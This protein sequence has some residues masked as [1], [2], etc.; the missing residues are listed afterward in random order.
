MSTQVG[1]TTK[2]FG[3]N[4]NISVS[5]VGGDE[6]LSSSVLR[7]NTIIIDSRIDRNFEDIGTYAMFITDS[8]GKAVRLTYTIQPGNGLYVDEAD[9]DK[10]KM[11]IDGISIMAN[12]GDELYVNRNN[13]IDNNTLLSTGGKIRV[14]TTSLLR[15]T[16]SSVGVVKGDEHTITVSGGSMSVITY[17]LDTVDDESNRD[18]IMCHSSEMNRT[19]EAIDGKLNVLTQNLDKADDDTFGVI[20]TDGITT[21]ADDNGKLSVITSGLEDAHYAQKGIVCGDGL[22][23]VAVDGVLSV[24]T[25]NL[26]PADSDNYGVVMIDGY[27]LVTSKNN[28][29]LEVYR[30]PEIEALLETNNPEHEIFRRDIEDLKN[31][32]SKLETTHQQEI[33]DFFIPVGEQTT[34]LPEPVFDKKTWQIAERYTDRKTISFQIKSNCKF[35]I[36]VEYKE[37]TNDYG[38]VTLLNVQE[39]S[40]VT[41][42]ANDLAN[43]IFEATGNTVQTINFTFEV[44]NYDKDNNQSCENTQVI[45]TATSINDAAIKQTSFHIFKCWNNLAYGEDKP[46]YDDPEVFIE[47]ESY[48]VVYPKTA[49]L[50]LYDSATESQTA[51]LQYN[52]TSS[53]NYYFNTYVYAAYT[54]YNP[55]EMKYNEPKHYWLNQSSTSE[56]GDY[57]VTVTT[58]SAD[59]SWVSAT[60]TTSYSTTRKFNVLQVKSTKPITTTSRTANITVALSPSTESQATIP[61]LPELTDTISTES[62]ESLINS[63]ENVMKT[64]GN[65]IRN[66]NVGEKIV[67]N[68]SLSTSLNTNPESITFTYYKIKN[69]IEELSKPGGLLSELNKK[70]NEVSNDESLLTDITE[71][72]KYSTLKQQ[73]TQTANKII[74]EYGVARQITNKISD[75][76]SDTLPKQLEFKYTELLNA[77]N[78]EIFVKATI[79]PEKSGITFTMTRNASSYVVNDKWSFTPKYIFINKNG[80]VVD[81]SGNNT[82][83]EYSADAMY[84]GTAITYTKD[85]YTSQIEEARTGQEVTENVN[86]SYYKIVT[87]S[88]STNDRHSLWGIGNGHKDE[89][90]AYWGSYDPD[91]KN[92]S[93]TLSSIDDDLYLIFKLTGQDA[94]YNKNQKYSFYSLNLRSKTNGYTKA[95]E[96][97]DTIEFMG[98]SGTWLADPDQKINT[99]SYGVTVKKESTIYILKNVARTSATKECKQSAEAEKT[100]LNTCSREYF[101]SHQTTLVANYETKTSQ[102]AS[103]I[104]GI[105]ITEIKLNPTNPFVGSEPVIT[106]EVSGSWNTSSSSGSSSSGSSSSGS[107]SSGSSTGNYTFGGAVLSNVYIERWDDI[108][109]TLRFT[110]RGGTGTNI[111][112]DTT[113]IE[114]SSST[115]PTK[116]TLLQGANSYD[117]TMFYNNKS[118][119]I[120]NWTSN[121][122]TVTYRLYNNYSLYETGSMD[123]EETMYNKSLQKLQRYYTDMS[124]RASIN[125]NFRSRNMTYQQQPYLTS[126]SGVKVFFAITT[127]S[128][129][130][131]K[132][133]ETSTSSMGVQLNFSGTYETGASQSVNIVNAIYNSTTTT[134]NTTRT[135][136]GGGTSGNLYYTNGV[137]NTI[138]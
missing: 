116:I 16:S 76:S 69:D 31:R 29:K 81:A 32:V 82:T 22:T 136:G 126:I 108:E 2:V 127:N 105:K 5:N 53:K 10:L 91:P 26:E 61:E 35:N 78:A 65:N 56:A 39:S 115:G 133:F 112:N 63:T 19:I 45:V 134:S 75:I 111:P 128:I 15:A 9:H 21:M 66:I 138:Y 62:V 109:M 104:A 25:H 135:S 14:E 42:P 71:H 137:G 96:Q 55:I 48:W 92:N 90:I 4:Y 130:V 36:N 85:Y 74:K 58:S 30:Y 17:N 93:H 94:K 103:S 43:T 24:L 89:G 67:K 40:S 106:S 100:L 3:R 113:I 84:P 54:Y 18:G 125:V 20:K 47:G 68:A 37:N 117:S 95:F 6:I 57:K 124:I 60:I 107:S 41:I 44:K 49:Y 7:E 129:S 98:I 52:S 97:A 122:C 51:Y 114:A 132:R 27:S 8:D 11:R 46:V 88:A 87:I 77:T 38:Q 13:I 12:D 99:A 28:G 80:D 110:I 120:S 72:N 121:S 73:V 1:N 23:A 33:I 118:V 83:K 102:V 34:I 131:G 101:T 123:L 119:T 59:T 64:I 86:Y 70:Y 79:S 50:Q